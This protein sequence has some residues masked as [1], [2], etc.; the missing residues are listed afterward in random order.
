MAPRFSDMAHVEPVGIHVHMGRHSKKL[1]VW[2]SWVR[3]CVLTA[4]GLSD[5]MDGWVPG[6][7]N[8]GGG[9]PS[10]PDRDTD[11]VVTGYDGPDLDGYASV[12]TGT[13]RDTL[14]EVG[15][16][17]SGMTVEVEPG[18]GLHS[19][20]GV[21]LTTVRNI[22]EETEYRPRKWAEVDTSEV[23]L[24]IP[25]FN[26]KP[27]FDYL[28]ANKVDEDNTITT[29][30]VG[31]TCNSELLFLQVEVPWLEPGDVVALLNTG[32]YSEP[33]A[34]NFNALPRPGTVLVNGASADLVK[35]HETVDEVFSRDEVPERLQ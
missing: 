34:A 17:G 7:M 11:I 22:K 8:F 13:L 14:R 18:R 6:V 12:I 21:H 10:F 5:L 2:Q 26:V 30:V 19:D 3:H 28:I 23:F 31:L 1:E 20:T 32:S 15:V 35:R 24:G 27:P 16:D 9:F 29:D 25:G 33:M 4:K